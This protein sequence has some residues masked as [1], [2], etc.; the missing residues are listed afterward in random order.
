MNRSRLLVVSHALPFPKSTGQSQ[1]VHYMLTALRERFHV[2]FATAG[3]AGRS[4]EIRNKLHE[5]CDNAVVLPTLYPRWRPA[6]VPH[7]IRSLVYQA[8]TGL[9]HS[10]YVI[11]RIE[12]T[13]ERLRE[14]AVRG[15]FDAVLYEYWHAAPSLRVFRERGIPTLLDMH[16]ILWRAYDAELKLKRSM[17]GWL[18]KRL[19]RMYRERE[20]AAW[21][22]FDALIAI[23]RDELDYVRAVVPA[24]PVFYGPM[25]I[26]LSEWPYAWRPPDRPRVAYYGGMSTKRNQEGALSVLREVMPSVWRRFPQAEFWIIGVGPPASI[27]ALASNPLIKVTGF[28]KDLAPLMATM[29]VVLCP[30]DG[31]YGFRSRMVEVLAVGVPS[32]CTPSAVAG[33]E[34]VERRAVL[35]A[36]TGEALAVQTLRLLENPVISEN[37]SR[38]GRRTVE[39]LF[40]YRNTYQ[41]LALEM[42]RWLAGREESH[43]EV[44][45]HIT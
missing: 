44:G 26:E 40:S 11:S 3:P 17:P 29:S 4:G 7:Q 33:M 14:V 24:Q 20:E 21:R 12:L 8:R 18:R 6:R 45:C 28:V 15:E 1:R 9:R 30:F 22:E 42:T 16:N 27:R 39:E 37:L 25:G 43:G 34:L 31:A 13:P 32:V 36:E 10:N 19:V 38:H 2:T 41:R 23:N 5:T 35:T